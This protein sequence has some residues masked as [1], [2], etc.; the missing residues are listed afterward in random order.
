MHIF[1]TGTDTDVGKTFV[2][3]AFTRAWDANYW[4][5]VQIGT[6][7]EAGDTETVAPTNILQ[8]PGGAFSPALSLGGISQREPRAGESG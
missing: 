7:T 4:K 3:A 2:A 6:L 8:A 1:V 5:P